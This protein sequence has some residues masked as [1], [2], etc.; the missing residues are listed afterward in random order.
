MLDG[1]RKRLVVVR[2][3]QHLGELGRRLADKVHGGDVLA[4]RCGK[5]GEVL[6]L[7]T[8]AEDQVYTLVRVCRERTPRRRHIRCL[9]VV[10]EPDT[11]DL[12]DGLEPVPHAGEAAEPGRD[13]RVLDP[14]CARGCRRRGGV[15]AVVRTTKERLGGQRIV[16]A[17]L[18][19]FETEPARNDS[20]ACPLEDSELCVS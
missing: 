8:S 15:L 10:D 9:R 17:E 14:D 11:A 6:A 2:A 19:S 13:Q 1:S 4:E 7:R 5:R 12:A 18:D 3:W 16:A 20:R